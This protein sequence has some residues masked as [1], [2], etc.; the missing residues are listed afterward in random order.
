MSSDGKLQRTGGRLL[1]DKGRLATVRASWL[2]GHCETE[3]Q[4]HVVV[5]VSGT[6]EN[7]NYPPDVCQHA[8]GTYEF[9]YCDE[10][11]YWPCAGRWRWKKIGPGDEIWHFFVEFSTDEHSQPCP[12]FDAWIAGDDTVTG[13]QYRF[14][15]ATCPPD[16][17]SCDRETGILGGVFDLPGE[18]RLEDQ[19][20]TGCTAH[21]TVGGP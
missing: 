17:V 2:P 15:Y 16:P 3:E 11:P 20:C 19:D 8:E 10:E 4:P 5:T 13:R 1:T 21:V 7:Y 9:E 12:Y 18:V 6:C 14:G